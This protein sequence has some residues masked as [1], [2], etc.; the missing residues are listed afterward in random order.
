MRLHSIMKGRC[1]TCCFLLLV[2]FLL[3]S[4]PTVHAKKQDSSDEN[5]TEEPPSRWKP[6]TKEQLQ[7]KVQE[8]ADQFH[9]DTQVIR[10]KVHEHADQFHKDTQVIRDKV[11]E[12]TE[13]FHKDA[14][15]VREKVHEHA[16]QFKEDVQEHAEHFKEGV[17]S[18]LPP[19]PTNIFQEI[20]NFGEQFQSDVQQIGEDF[21]KEV[22]TMQREFK[23]RLLKDFFQQR[24]GWERFRHSIRDHL[25]LLLGIWVTFRG[26]VHPWLASPENGGR[27]GALALQMGQFVWHFLDANTDLFHS[28]WSHDVLSLLVA[29]SFFKYAQP[30]K[31]SRVLNCVPHALFGIALLPFWSVVV[32]EWLAA[33]PSSAQQGSDIQ[34]PFAAVL[35]AVAVHMS[36]VKYLQVPIPLASSCLG[37]GILVYDSVRAEVRGNYIYMLETTAHFLLPTVHLVGRL[38]KLLLRPARA[39]WKRWLKGFWNN[40]LYPKATKSLVRRV[41]TT[42]RRVWKKATAPMNKVKDILAANPV[43]QKC[44]ELAM[45]FRKAFRPVLIPWGIAMWGVAVQMNYIT[46]IGGVWKVLRFSMDPISFLKERLKGYFSPDSYA[47]KVVIKTARS[48]PQMLGKLLPATVDNNKLDQGR[49]AGKGR[50][51]V[52]G[53][54]GRFSRKR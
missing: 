37:G 38:L 44:N 19:A 29:S 10:D 34:A 11:H 12:H 54:T 46:N 53:N 52:S 28:P 30:K 45:R 1:A 17:K 50:S 33:D 31:N 8:H 27:G 43:V 5:E 35:A 21:F 26:Q 16:E 42:I 2:I 47:R 25:G 22:Q 32:E 40:V 49:N 20:Q 18:I 23:K 9:K 14:Q 24:V 39:V 3:G 7:E 48:I 13:Q 4:F 51:G 36:Y 15:I 6:L 41:I